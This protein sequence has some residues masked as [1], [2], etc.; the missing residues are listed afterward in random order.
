MQVSKVNTK[1]LYK[2]FACWPEDKQIKALLVGMNRVYEDLSDKELAK[3][4]MRRYIDGELEHL[5]D[6]L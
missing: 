6:D 2:Q 3:V 5:I 4:F 1:E